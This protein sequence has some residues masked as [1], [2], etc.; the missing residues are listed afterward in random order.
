MS[1]CYPESPKVTLNRV[2]PQYKESKGE[3]ANK[4]GKMTELKN[5]KRVTGNEEKEGYQGMLNLKYLKI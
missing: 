2:R 5:C 3:D 4:K 1:M